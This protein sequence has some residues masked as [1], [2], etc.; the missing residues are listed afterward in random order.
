MLILYSSYLEEANILFFIKR[1][2]FK[3]KEQEKSPRKI[4]AIDVGLAN[5]VGFKFSAD[6]GKVAENIVAA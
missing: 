6:F 5:A 2:S 4:Y 1:F 3:V